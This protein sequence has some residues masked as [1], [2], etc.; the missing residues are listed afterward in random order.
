MTRHAAQTLLID[1]DDTLWENNVYFERVI[2][3]AQEMLESYGVDR[4]VFRACLDDLERRHIAVDGYGTLNFTRSLVAAFERFLPPGA[5]PELSGKVEALALGILEH[6]IELLEGVPETLAYLALRHRLYLITKGDLVEQSR[7]IEASRLA[8]YFAGIEIL[9]E[10]HPESYRALVDRH[11]WDARRTWMIGNSVRSDI[12]P[13]LSAGLN[14]V[15]IPQPHT[16]VLEREDPAHPSR[17]LEIERF[18]D[19]RRHF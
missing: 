16:W 10:K 14:A 2:E 17:V 7:K 11:S 5:D 9:G 12:N 15:F 6:P 3:A 8:S 13:A 18:S 1:A 19:L 4:A